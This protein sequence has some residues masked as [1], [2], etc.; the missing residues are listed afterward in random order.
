MADD[1]DTPVGIVIH[2]GQHCTTIDGRE[3]PL[4]RE[5]GVRTWGNDP[6]GKTMMLTGTYHLPGEI[7]G[8]VLAALPSFVVLRQDE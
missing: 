8:R 7:S 5:L 4:P 2:P 1:P 6:D 3:V